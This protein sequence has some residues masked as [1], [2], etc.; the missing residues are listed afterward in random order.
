T[1]NDLIAAEMSKRYKVPP[2]LVLLNCPDP[3]S[4]FDPNA[5][6]DLIRAQIGLSPERK[7]VLY[8]GWMSEGRGLENLVRAA[9]LLANDAV[10]VFMGYGDY[11]AI[12]QS[13]VDS[14]GSGRVY[15]IPAVPQRDLLAYC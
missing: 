9:A 15:F 6:Y 11:Q 10:V 3:P 8:Q 4:S 14:E 1:V 2:P 7:I 5:H 13:M 12:L